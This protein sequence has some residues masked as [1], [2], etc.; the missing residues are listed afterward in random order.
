MMEKSKLDSNVFLCAHT[1]TS[2]SSVCAWMFWNTHLY[3]LMSWYFVTLKLIMW[4]TGP[5]EALV[6]RRKST[7]VRL[8]VTFGESPSW[9]FVT[10]R[11]E[12]KHSANHTA[13]FGYL[14]LSPGWCDLW[15]SWSLFSFDF[16]AGPSLHVFIA[17]AERVSSCPE[18]N[19]WSNYLQWCTWESPE[20][21]Y[22]VQ[23]G[24][25]CYSFIP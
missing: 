12:V 19:W 15:T 9:N 13:V 4:E 8:L 10:L 17:L 22:A 7:P 1:P 5:T 6:T 24:S 14:S 23:D 11:G 18:S 20:Q 3:I 21:G 16:P 2:L 25:D